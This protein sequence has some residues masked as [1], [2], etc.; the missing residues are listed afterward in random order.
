MVAELEAENKKL[1]E[2]QGTSSGVKS[3]NSQ[4][5]QSFNMSSSTKPVIGGT[6]RDQ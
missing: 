4:F 1:K 6:N 5:S 3:L 2:E